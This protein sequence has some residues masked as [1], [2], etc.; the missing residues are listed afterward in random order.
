MPRRSSRNKRRWS[1]PVRSDRA[2]PAPAGARPGARGEGHELRSRCLPSRR[3]CGDADLGRQSAGTAAAAAARDTAASDSREPPS[4]AAR[5]GYA[6]SRAAPARRRPRPEVA[7]PAKPIPKALHHTQLFLDP[8]EAAPEP[9]APVTS[10][11]EMMEAIL[12]GS[13]DAP[14]VAYEAPE[15]PPAPPVDSPKIP[16]GHSNSATQFFPGAS[17]LPSPEPPPPPPPPEEDFFHGSPG[18][19]SLSLDY[20]EP[21]PAPPAADRKRPSRSSKRWSSKT[22]SPC[23]P[24]SRRHTPVS[25]RARARADW[26]SSR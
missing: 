12:D 11:G 7:P 19:A 9:A 6:R 4:H 16:E 5:G 3:G 26:S 15:R 22:P 17:A 25:P 13:G 24:L 23:R 10:T 14:A 20:D 18:F 1:P 2:E 21:A 8:P